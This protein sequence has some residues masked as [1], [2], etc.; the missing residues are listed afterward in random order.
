MVLGSRVLSPGHARRAR[1]HDTTR[2]A[3]CDIARNQARR[4]L[5]EVGNILQPTGCNI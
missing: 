4:P 5:Q 3:R 1:I 2:N